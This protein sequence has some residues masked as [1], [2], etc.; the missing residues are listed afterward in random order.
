MKR[1]TTQKRTPQAPLGAPQQQAAQEQA[2][3]VTA[4]TATVRRTRRR[5]RKSLCDIPTQEEV[6]Q[7]VAEAQLTL[8]D[9]TE[10]YLYH[11]ARGWR[12]GS[13]GEGL[14]VRDWRALAR[15]WQYCRERKR[16]QS[17][18]TPKPSREQRM[19]QWQ[20]EHLPL[21]HE[22]TSEEKHYEAHYAPSR[23]ESFSSPEVVRTVRAT[24]PATIGQCLR[25]MQPN[26]ILRVAMRHLAITDRLC[27]PSSRPIALDDLSC[28][29]KTLLLSYQHLTM[30][31]LLLALSQI[32]RGRYGDFY[33]H[34]TTPRL[35]Q[36]MKRFGKWRT[37]ELKMF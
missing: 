13:C 5:K 16:K 30:S 21:A 34:L 36:A 31:E 14:P 20:E 24:R 9:A 26:L 27:N 23:H 3:S 1:N 29:A 10:F 18:Q 7:Y 4:A 12:V 8:V 15:Y 25:R 19:Q 22:T 32:E 28:L 6:E 33:G 35:L 37:E 17:A 11:Q 2:Q